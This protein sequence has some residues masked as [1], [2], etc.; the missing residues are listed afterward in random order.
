[1]IAPSRFR[2]TPRPDLSPITRRLNVQLGELNRSI[3]DAETATAVGDLSSALLNV[4]A[5]LENDLIISRGRSTTRTL[6]R[7]AS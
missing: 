6:T 5:E 1:M 4:I 2:L 7:T 3:L